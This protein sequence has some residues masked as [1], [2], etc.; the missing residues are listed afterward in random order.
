MSSLSG[1]FSNTDSTGHI[2]VRVEWSATQSISNN[3][4]TVTVDTF[5]ECQFAVNFS[6]SK[7]GNTTLTPAG[8]SAISR[9]WNY[10]SGVNTS[11]GWSKH[12]LRRET[13]T[14]SHNSD[15]TRSFNLS[16]RF[17]IAIT[18][19]SYIAS[20]TA[21][22][23]NIVLRPIPRTSSITSSASW[24]AP[25]NFNV[26]ISAADSSLR[27]N[28]RIQVQDTGSTWRTIKTLSN[29]AGGTTGSAFS[30]AQNKD[31]FTR[32][33][34]QSSRPARLEMDTLTG[35]NGTVIGTTTVTGTVSAPAASTIASGVA[36]FNIGAN[37]SGAI[38]RHHTSFT[39]TVRFRFGTTLVSTLT[40]QTTSI[41]FTPT[42][43]NLTNMYAATPNSNSVST[44]VEV[45]TLYDGQIVR[46]TTTR[47]G[48]ATVINSNPTFALSWTFAETNTGLNTHKGAG[49]E[50]VMIQGLSTVRA[51]ITTAQRATANNGATMVR[52]VATLNGVERTA[53]WSETATITLDFGTINAS[54]NTTLTIT[55]VDSRGNTTSTSR[56]VTVVPYTIPTLNATVTRLNNFE[57]QTTLTS[58]GSISLVNIGGTNR[59]ALTHLEYRSKL[60]TSSTWPTTWTNI[61]RSISGATFTGNNVVL[62][63]PNTNAY[64]FEIRAVD[65]FGHRTLA[66]KVSSGRPILFIDADRNSVGINTF[67]NSNNILEVGGLVRINMNS[68]I[69]GLDMMNSNIVGVNRLVIADP[70]VDEGI[71][72]EGGN[73]WKIYESPNNLTNASGNLQFVTNSTR[74]MTLDTAGN[75][76]VSGALDLSSSGV[77]N[78]ASITHN[79]RTRDLLIA[80]NTTVTNSGAWIELWANGTRGDGTVAQAR[81]GELSMGGRE[82]TF[83]TNST[84]SSAGTERVKIDASGNTTFTGSVTASSFSGSIAASNLTGTIANAR[85]SGS[86]DGL[87]NLTASTF[88]GNADDSVTAPAHSWA[89]DTNTGMYRVSDT[90]IGFTIN[91]TRR[92]AVNASRTFINGLEPIGTSD[93]YWNYYNFSS[94]DGA[95]AQNIAFATSKHHFGYIGR[96]NA[97]HWRSFANGHTNTSDR[98]QKTDIREFD[99]EYAYNIIKD[100]NV[101][102]YYFVGKDPNERRLGIMADE[103]PY[104][105]VDIE[106]YPERRAIDI[107]AW[108]SLNSS[109]MKHM[110]MKM[111]NSDEKILVME[112][113]MESIK[114]EIAEMKQLVLQ[115]TGGM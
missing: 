66:R 74:R 58:V 82:I 51:S 14:V 42:G 78:V 81:D 27:H 65:R 1:S 80:S 2:R 70:G 85:L 38:T 88:R 56:T 31:I 35:S 5:L 47:T 21:S 92:M 53:N 6:A 107:Y 20:I 17:D 37:I 16:S 48:T 79:N 8:S 32:M 115:L 22:A 24:T 109:A 97:A 12:A 11:G 63:L 73:G 113:E 30:V 23:S 96:S 98:K 106:G 34:G 19:G 26:V 86:Y 64:D 94:G 105:I 54:A 57:E 9:N 50:A 44:T 36:S 49:N 62:N 69:D 29:I 112:E 72:W 89:S 39:H 61:T 111:E 46:S 76:W 43:T 55:A 110:Q 104:E 99:G 3:T 7:S 45:D 59:N 10:T 33:N 25:D 101:Y 114:R 75:L 100:M 108:S 15:G 71:E 103:A 93:H 40:N 28:V 67:P 4:S 90:E 91:G 52:Y 77:S 60:A 87:T 13:F 18:Y 84:T 41:N 95:T 83:R 68:A 102:T